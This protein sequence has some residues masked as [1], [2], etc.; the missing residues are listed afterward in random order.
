VPEH[1]EREAQPV[2]VDDFAGSQRAKQAALEHGFCQE[3][4]GFKMSAMFP[5]PYHRK[6]VVHW[7]GANPRSPEH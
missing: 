3:G 5:G 2:F 6:S 1:R 7:P 4:P